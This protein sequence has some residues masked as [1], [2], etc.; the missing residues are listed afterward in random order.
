MKVTCA[1]RQHTS[2]P[3]DAL[4]ESQPISLD[5][6]G[7]A[8]GCGYLRCPS[9]VSI[10]ASR[11]TALEPIANDISQTSDPPSMENTLKWQPF[12]E[13]DPVGF[14]WATFDLLFFATP[15]CYS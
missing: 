12:L 7:T 2:G 8:A 13:P 14:I 15:H 4:P 5:F 10:V 6:L 1:R 11:H 9:S 3:L